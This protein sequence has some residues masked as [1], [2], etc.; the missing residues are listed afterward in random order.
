MIC[1]WERLKRNCFSIFKHLEHSVI[2]DHLRKSKWFFLTTPCNEGR[3]LDPWPCPLITTEC[4]WHVFNEQCSLRQKLGLGE[5]GV[6][7]LQMAVENKGE[8][9]KSFHSNSKVS[10]KREWYSFFSS[11][12]FI[13]PPSLFSSFA[14][15]FLPSPHPWQSPISYF[16][17]LSFILFCFLFLQTIA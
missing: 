7:M 3:L 4:Y 13:L 14:F 8:W 1:I 9:T 17:F 16:P 6:Y 2:Y 12:P 10:M 11:L 5:G 15:S